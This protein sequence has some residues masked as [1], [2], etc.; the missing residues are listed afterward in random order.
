[1]SQCFIRTSSKNIS[2]ENFS[3]RKNRIV[4]C[5]RTVFRNDQYAKCQS[6]D[7]SI[8][9]SRSAYNN[10]I[11]NPTSNFHSIT[12]KNIPSIYISNN[13]I[14]ECLPINTM[15]AYLSIENDPNIFYIY[16]IN[17][18]NNFYIKNNVLYTRKTFIY[19]YDNDENNNIE[20]YLVAYKCTENK[21]CNTIKK[22]S[23]IKINSSQYIQ[24]ILSICDIEYSKNN[25]LLSY[26]N[27]TQKDEIKLLKKI[28][29]Y[30]YFN[31]NIVEND[32]IVNTSFINNVE[33]IYK[34]LITTIYTDEHNNEFYINT[35][36]DKKILDTISVTGEYKESST[37]SIKFNDD[38]NNIYN[39]YNQYFWWTVENVNESYVY[40]IINNENNN[41]Y[42]ITANDIGKNI[43]ASVVYRN[44][45][46]IVIRSKSPMTPII[47]NIDNLPTGIVK[48][49][50]NPN[51]GKYLNIADNIN[52][53]DGIKHKTITWY[54]SKKE[55]G[56]ITNVIY[57]WQISTNKTDWSPIEYSN[58]KYFYIP[59]NDNYK[60]KF[61]RIKADV[62]DIYGNKTIFYSS[63][64][65][66]S[67]EIN[68]EVQPE[69]FKYS[70]KGNSLIGE[71]LQIY[72]ENNNIM[73]Q[74][75]NIQYIWYRSHNKIDWTII[76]Q[77][78]FLP[79]VILPL[80]QENLYLNNYIKSTVV[81]NDGKNINYYDTN[82]SNI[83]TNYNLF[84]G[85]TV[86]VDG[87]PLEG[88]KLTV[89]L[90]TNESI[91]LDD[92]DIRYY[93]QTSRDNIVWK[94]LS[95]DE[96]YSLQYLE[97]QLSYI[98]TEDNQ[99]L[100]VSND[101]RSMIIPSNGSFIDSVIRCK[102]LLTKNSITEFIISNITSKIKNTNS[103][104]T[105][106][107][108]ITGSSKLNT[109]IQSTIT[110]LEDIDGPI[111]IKSYLWQISSNPE[112]NS[113]WT[114]TGTNNSHFDIPNDD[115]F[116]GKSIR[117][118]VSCID[119]RGGISVLYSNI[120]DIKTNDATADYKIFISGNT[121]EGSTLSVVLDGSLQKNNVVKYLWKYT[122]DKE[123][124]FTIV[125]VDN[126]D[127]LLIPKNNTYIG[128][129]ISVEIIYNNNNEIVNYTSPYTNKI[130][131]L[132]NQAEGSLQLQGTPMLG[133]EMYAF[134][135]GL[136]DQDNIVV[137]NNNQPFRENQ[138]YIDNKYLDVRFKASISYTDNFGEY[139]IIYSDYSNYIT[140][141]TEINSIPDNPCY[142]MTDTL[143]YDF[144]NS[145]NECRH[146]IIGIGG[147]VNITED[148]ILS[149]RQ[150]I[151]VDG[152]TFN[153]NYC[154]VTLMNFSQFLIL[155]GGILNIYGG[156]I[157]IFE[158]ATY[159]IDEES[160]NTI[161]DKPFG[162]DPKCNITT[163]INND[164][165][166]SILNNCDIINIAVGGVVNLNKTLVIKSGKNIVI[167]RHGKLIANNSNIIL[168]SGA[169]LCIYG[170]FE[171]TGSF[172]ANNDSYFYVD[173]IGIYNNSQYI[174]NNRIVVNK[175]ISYS[176]LEEY[177]KHNYEIVIG[178]N[179][180]FTDTNATI[181][182]ENLN[183]LIID[184]DSS[185]SLSNC[186]LNIKEGATLI[187]NGKFNR[188]NGEINVEIN[189]T[190]MFGEESIILI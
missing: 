165:F 97:N 107:V 29:W 184:K 52:D 134:F 135:E 116:I 9:T 64:I 33:Q 103:N 153:I 105:G 46:T 176:E 32:Y 168:E 45:E 56:E 138:L 126:K 132:N 151:V 156:N 23:I 190:F 150:R 82:T 130:I 81:V 92:Y 113:S 37:L 188:K 182:I 42:T 77:N 133:Q 154:N 99:N 1:M 25:D 31:N 148:L 63:N 94:T 85:A 51:I 68:D 26:L 129:Y 131:Y 34:I 112:S 69:I 96:L 2:S 49:L 162:P 59:I 163:S 147:I 172:V 12:F 109:T 166:L 177:F 41:N 39:K 24:N 61:L 7:S 146:V 145:L 6:V 189:S 160:Y 128:K 43:I 38:S 137:D 27:P 102:V 123:K 58:N 167:N 89:L 57:E 175:T 139:N 48:I 83:I 108:T 158:K 98:R 53:I 183:S 141:E 159:Y 140:D 174:S 16:K 67:I 36:F 66:D 179:G 119:S 10:I 80:S 149:G 142:F 88:S 74:N 178:E 44:N 170:E 111:L 106:I 164:L 187:I 55:Y 143:E 75:T 95:T 100:V 181:T 157:T 22:K 72:D 86:T 186:I 91:N 125:N 40:N 3:S 50:G 30:N 11:N 161:D 115:S 118:Y 19:D 71:T 101:N 18:S 17:N 47:T 60:D 110:N 79:N 54:Q 21:Q 20:I 70:L 5:Q 73:K 62:Y 8:R 144:Y 169:S 4:S 120:T 76:T 15:V 155:R 173:K 117:L 152:G 65:S 121:I 78:R 28:V 185:I 90:S 87:K 14:Y 13:E 122:Y 127:S 180:S 104:T 124:T 136:Y 114:N 35:I 171:L 84:N 93:W